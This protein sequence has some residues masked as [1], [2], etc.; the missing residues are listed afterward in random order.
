LL[1]KKQYTAVK[2]ICNIQTNIHVD[3]Q[4]PTLGLYAAC[5]WLYKV[6]NA[7][8]PASEMISIIILKLGGPITHCHTTLAKDFMA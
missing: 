5:I 3:R 2:H 8:V 6:I 4:L 1:G 7:G